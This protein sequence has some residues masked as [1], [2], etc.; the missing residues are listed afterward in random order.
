MNTTPSGQRRSLSRRT[1]LLGGL[2]I[3]AIGAPTTVACTTVIPIPSDPIPITPD[4]TPSATDLAPSATLTGHTSWISSVAFSP[5][6]KLLATG[7]LD[8]NVKLW[9]TR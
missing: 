5:D 2:G 7:S 8:N 6:G 3:L 1:L 4:P 9:P